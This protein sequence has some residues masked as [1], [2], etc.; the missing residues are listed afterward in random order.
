MRKL[1]YLLLF[2]VSFVTVQAQVANPAKWQTKI[3]KKSDT[4]Y[5]ITWDGV[6][7]EGWH[8]YS[9]YTPEGGP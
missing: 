8:M 7:A 2:L 6:I 9:Q 4:E 1:A 3:E 5:T